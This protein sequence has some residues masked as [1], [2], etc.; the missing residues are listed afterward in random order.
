MYYLPIFFN[1][2]NIGTTNHINQDY[3][4]IIEHLL[5]HARR[6]FDQALNNDRDRAQAMLTMM[7]PLYQMEQIAKEYQLSIEET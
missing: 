3:T 2:Y 6:K 5:A 1:R 7:Q 4:F